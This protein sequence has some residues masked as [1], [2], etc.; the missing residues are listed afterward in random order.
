[1]LSTF[2]MFATCRLGIM[3]SQKALTITGNNIGNINTVGYS[4]QTLKQNSF[5]TGGA[6]RYYNSADVR[7]GAGAIVNG[8]AQLRDPYLDI[9][10]RNEM[11]AVGAMDKKLDGLNNIAK[12]LDEVGLGTDG[13][14]LFEDNLNGVISALQALSDPNA[15]GQQQTD[16]EVRSQIEKLCDLFHTYDT[17]L[18]QLYKEAD[19]EFRSDLKEV[20]SILRSIRNYNTEIRRASIFGSE[21]L[22]QQDERNVLIDQLA[23]HIKIDVTREMEDL[24][25]GLRVEKLV[26]K[27]A[28]VPQ[29]TLIDG[30]YG[31]QLSIR[32][33]PVTNENG[34]FLDKD[35]NVVADEKDAALMDSP[36]YDLDI[37][38]LKDTYGREIPVEKTDI[39][40]KDAL[41]AIYE[42]MAQAALDKAIADGTLL[43]Q[44]ANGNPI[45]YELKKN[46]DGTYGANKISLVDKETTIYTYT[47]PT[48]IT[49]P[50][51]PEDL[52]SQRL[53]E[54]KNT[55]PDMF[56]EKDE[57]GNEYEYKIN[58]VTP[59]APGAAPT[60]EFC[61]VEKVEVE[62]EVDPAVFTFKPDELDL[63]DKD[64][65]Q[66]QV[67]NLETGEMILENGN[68]VDRQYEVVLNENTKEYE[69]H[70]IDSFKGA[71]ELKD[72]EL[73]GSLQSQ[74]ELL[75]E[76]GEFASEEQIA[77]D[78][79]ATTKRGILYYQH[80]WDNLA[81]M[82]ASIFNDNNPQI[83]ETK[84]GEKVN[85]SQMLS[86]DYGGKTY[87]FKTEKDE[88]GDVYIPL[89]DDCDYYSPDWG[90]DDKRFYIN[91]NDD[92][93]INFESDHYDAVETL[94]HFVNRPEHSTFYTMD[95]MKE[96]PVAGGTLISN[97]SNAN[98]PEG[99]D[100][101]N[102]AIS[103]QWSINQIRILLS[104]D[105]NA[106]STMQDNIIHILSQMQTAT[107]NFMPQDVV[108]DAAST[109]E[110]FSGTIQNALTDIWNVLS[111]DQNV[112]TAALSSYATSADELYV[113]RDAVMGVDLNEEAM[114]MMQ[115]QKSYSAACRLMTV[116]DTVLDKLINGT[117]VTT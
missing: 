17:K 78:S 77:I 65:V 73:Y 95:D 4:R 21:A 97:N 112:T 24:G 88:N 106:P 43:S 64:A 19:E 62:E 47:P 56:P 41:N 23:E 2:G 101:S 74:R 7:I 34:E 75:T 92:G 61:R 6:D 91:Y 15:A 51:T 5:Y 84:D 44:D 72:T 69:I 33:I 22:E 107:H 116:Y 89:S 80:A 49:P 63:T 109:E 94:E 35:G 11:S 117:G 13:E 114:N 71:A 37:A 81:K 87:Y 86:V 10:Y 48:G 12:V 102:I 36:N 52:A 27:T 3:A 93:S 31:T 113:D 50:S 54:L 8:T 14:G 83:Y 39:V 55:R 98:D 20:N 67:D 100:A 1:M 16:T 111:T 29:R 40:D 68:I 46:E 30:I 70:R 103:H 26:I 28:N 115:F 45:R 38:T 79:A 90:E 25:D 66:E 110:Y 9:R 32:Q 104:Q 42:Q 59:T 108:E 53:D 76:E 58:D 57:N 85:L 82:F 60:F 105:P 99:I 96:N 18:N